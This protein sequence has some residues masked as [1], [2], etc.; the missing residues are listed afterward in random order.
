M[1]MALDSV[2]A[3]TILGVLKARMERKWIVSELETCTEVPRLNKG[4]QDAYEPI[5]IYLFCFAICLKTTQML[6]NL[7]CMLWFMKKYSMPRDKKTLCLLLA[8]PLIAARN[9]YVCSICF[10][11]LD[12]EPVYV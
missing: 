2:Y 7:N 5:F 10:M 1:L 8:Y 12:T 9:K 3:G 4:P 6:L 11:S